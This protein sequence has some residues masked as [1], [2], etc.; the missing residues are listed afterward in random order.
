MEEEFGILNTSHIIRDLYGQILVIVCA[1]I[2]ESRGAR[3][4]VLIPFA[5]RSIPKYFGRLLYR[6]GDQGIINAIHII[7]TVNDNKLFG[8]ISGTKQWIGLYS[9][10]LP[11]GEYKRSFFEI[12]RLKRETVRVEMKRDQQLLP[13]LLLWT[14]ELSCRFNFPYLQRVFAA[15]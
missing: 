3:G 4:F 15:L 5:F 6:E 12:K 10:Y 14:K 13:R 11:T 2:G 9:A 7:I 1:E 8:R